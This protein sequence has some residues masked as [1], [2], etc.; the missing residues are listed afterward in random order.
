MTTSSYKRLSQGEAM[1]LAP[2][3]TVVVPALN[4][5]ETITRTIDNL[6][7]VLGQMVN[8]F[9][10]IV[11][12]D[13]S[14]DGTFEIASDTGVRVL[15]LSRNFGKEQA[16]MA[17]LS[18][19]TG[20]ATAIIDAD[21]QENANNLV[22]MYERYK[23][24]YD[25]VY[26]V[27]ANRDDEPMTKRLFSKVFYRL[28]EMGNDVKIPADA[29]DFR[30]MDRKVVNALL[31]LPERNRFMKGLYAW[32]G[33][34]STSFP[35]EMAPREGGNSKFG[36]RPLAQ[37]SLTALTSFTDWPLRIW[38]GIGFFIALL[39]FL[40]GTWIFAKTLIWGAET[41]GFA[42]ITVA[43]FFLGGIQLISIGIIG[44]YLARMFTELKGR[45]GFIIADEAGE[46]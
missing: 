19:S 9:E 24:G 22:G 43:V 3:L 15:R 35:M 21:L 16:I 33:F 8:K 2:D 13:G 38:T 28:L 5:A 23:Q 14:I 11:V 20:T 17:G 18:R 34:R 46:E 6:K 25:M 1:P 27:R 7:L 4:E 30:I 26:A 29:R 45:P 10:I 42:T 40:N 44:E 36:F 41:P 12:D 37:L 31:E 39:S 32:V